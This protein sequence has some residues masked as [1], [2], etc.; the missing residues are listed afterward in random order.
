MKLTQVAVDR[1]ITTSMLVGIVIVISVVSLSRLPIDLMPDI[2]F[3]SLSVS[4]NYPGATPEEMETLVTRPIEEAMGSV[5]NVDTL[6]TQSSEE[7]SSVRLQFEWGTDIDEAANEVRQRLDRLRRSL[8]EEVEAPVL[9]K[10]DINQS[11]IMR[12]GLASNAM[13]LAD[14]RYLAEHSIKPRLERAPGVASVDVGGGRLRE[15]QVDL[16]GEKLEALEIAPQTIVQAIRAENVNL[17]AGEV[18]SGDTQLVMRTQGQFS[19]PTE[20]ANI[21]VAQRDGIPI[22]LRDVADIEDGFEELRQIER[23]DGEPGIRMYLYKQSGSNTV[24]VADQVLKEIERIRRDYPQVKVIV[25]SDSSQF[26][27]NAISNVRS[28]ALYGSLLAIVILLLFLRNLRSTLII[29]TSIPV[30][31]MAAFSLIYFAGFTLNIVSFGGLALGVGLLVDSSIVV[32]EN[33]FRHRESGQPAREA[34]IEGTREVSTAIVASTLTTLVV[35]LPLLFLS[36]AASIMFTQLAYVVAFSLLCSLMVSL[37]LIPTLARRL[38]RVESLESEPNETLLHKIYRVSE[39]GLN[40]LELAYRRL[41]HFALKHRI[42]ATACAFLLLAVTIPLRNALGYEYMPAADEGEVDIYARMAP[43]TKLEALDEVFTKLENIAADEAGDETEH[44]TTRFGMSSWGRGGGSNTGNIELMLK[45]VSERTRSSEEIANDL[46]Q[47]IQGIPGARTFA[48][49]GGGLFIFRIMQPEGESMGV[50]VRGYDREVGYHL[51][52][53]VQKKLEGIEGISDPQMRRSE[54]RPEIS[55]EIDRYKAAEAGFTVSSVA[56]TIRTSFGGQVAT[57]YREGGDEFNVR[58]RLQED[59]RQTLKDLRTTWII[60][61]DGQR[62]PV[63]N[64]MEQ[65]RTVGPTEIQRKNQERYLMVSADIEPEYTLGNVMREVESELATLDMPEGF[66]LVYGGE[67]EEQQKS[68]RDLMMGLALAIILVYMV[69]AAQF[70][71]LIQPFVIMFAIPFASIGVLLMLWITNT[72]VNVQSFLG[73]I[74]LVGIVVNNAIVLVDYTNLLRREQGLSLHEAIE[75]AG[76]RR[77]RPILMTTSTTVLAL[78]P[79]AI[80]LGS[81]GE[82]QAPMARVVIGGLLTSTLVTL[83]LIPIVYTTVEE[84]MARFRK[85]ESP[86]TQYA[87]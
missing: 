18:F 31:I 74:V 49:A 42:A 3:P 32:L 1:P 15:I 41:L 84:F 54:G 50:E 37:T 60:A 26:I 87:K 28:A 55:L 77:L 11:S 30:S 66:T 56:E 38:L 82:L 27:R 81:G 52:E 40:R 13:P 61:P 62:V 39:Q 68:Y 21:V 79:M 64:F 47:S 43:G 53:Q 72:S 65:K 17:P 46:R 5:S 6:E 8:P 48:R 19:A 34:A 75:Q 25:L 67:Y 59:D 14:L 16:I 20:L 69:M 4:V 36:G 58:V 85:Q 10:F 9:Y 73:M 63:T 12:F 24:A 44:I 51:A 76:R 23:I 7:S 22:Y 2:T 35:F 86:N 71:S 70:E 78:V 83:V 45:P 33:I 57:R 29:A 80:G